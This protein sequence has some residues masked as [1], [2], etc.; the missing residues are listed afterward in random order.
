MTTTFRSLCASELTK[1]TTTRAPRWIL[2]SAAL[3]AALVISGLVAS[4]VLPDDE[5]A[6]D[7]ALRTVFVH[8]GLGSILPLILGILISAGEYRHGTVV[9]TFLTEPRRS[10]VVGAKLLTGTLVGVTAGLLIALATGATAAAWYSAKDVPLDLT[11]TLV[12]R[13]LAGIVLWVG[14]YA[15]I[16]VAVGSV[17]RAPAAAI[18]SVVVWLT[19]LE[20]AASG[21]VVSVGRWL[22]ATAASALGN[23]PDDGLLPQVGAGLVLLGWAALATA[24]AVVATARRDVT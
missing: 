13:S 12:L 8:G 21:L 14:L 2:V 5:L 17:I 3:L 22:P 20:T 23:A 18:V 9:D 10:R 16:G 24:G 19:I 4:G 1:L 6:T 11:S 7:A 15:V